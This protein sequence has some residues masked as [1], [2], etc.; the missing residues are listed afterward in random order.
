MSRSTE[1]NTSG[2]AT[3][4]GWKYRYYFI[5]VEE[6]DKTLRAK[7]ILCPV[8]KKPLSTAHYTTL[9]LKKHLKTVHKTTSS[10]RIQEWEME[11]RF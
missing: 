4:Y 8:H 3:I 6:T 1:F 9:N 7:C 2:N 11:D 5:V 10:R